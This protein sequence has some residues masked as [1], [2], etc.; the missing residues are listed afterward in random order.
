MKLTPAQLEALMSR[1][2]EKLGDRVAMQ[3]PANYGYPDSLALCIIDA[4][5]S[6]GI[7]YANVLKVTENYRNYRSAQGGNGSTD[8]VDQ[9]LA[10]F[11]QQGAAE[12]WAIKI[13]TGHKTST[14]RNAPV[15][16]VAMLA[17]AE[18]LASLGIRSTADLRKVA[19]NPDRLADAEEVWTGVVGQSSGITWRYGLMLAGVDGVKPDRM[20]KR[21]VAD[22]LGMN[23]KTMAAPFAESAVKEAASALEVT[24]TALDHAIWNWQRIPR[25]GS[26]GTS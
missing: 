4:V 15:K 11:A 25:K 10:T 19:K 23:W 16:P 7:K 9:L 2:T 20:I 12:T 6:T 1:C 17:I 5:Q 26:P 21:F 22:A 13:G 14:A 8:G 18:G 24:A 3:L